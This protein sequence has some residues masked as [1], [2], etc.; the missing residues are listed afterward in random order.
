MSTNLFVVVLEGCTDNWAREKPMEGVT[1]KIIFDKVTIPDKVL[2][3]KNEL[4]D[5][6][7]NRNDLNVVMTVGAGDIDTKVKEIKDMLEQK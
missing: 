5:L 3:T 1:S 4:I 7:K 2:A 6:L